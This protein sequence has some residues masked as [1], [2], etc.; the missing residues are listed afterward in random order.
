MH[1]NV[2]KRM[3]N[4][5]N[6]S[7]FSAAFCSAGFFSASSTGIFFLLP[8]VKG[9]LIYMHMA[10]QFSLPLLTDFGNKT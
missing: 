1:V 7:I 4:M 9:L 10:A 8:A 5:L 3:Y 6:R 2:L